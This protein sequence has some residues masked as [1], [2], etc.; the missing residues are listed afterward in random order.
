[1]AD[2]IKLVQGDT[3][4]DIDVMMT[5]ETTGTPI[6]V[7]DPGDVVK[8]YFRRVGTS[9]LIATMTCTKPNGGADG[10]VRIV[11]SSLALADGGEYEGELEITFSTGKIQTV[12]EKLLFTVRSQIG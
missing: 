11:W 4:P 8:F 12:Y 2:K 5:N 1:M 9:A 10:L 7:D 3:G 6:V